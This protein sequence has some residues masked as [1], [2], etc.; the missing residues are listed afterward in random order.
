MLSLPAIQG[1]FPV[2]VT[3]FVTPVRP[4]RPV[5]SAKLKNHLK[6]RPGQPDYAFLLEEV[7]YTAY[8][9]ADVGKLQ[10]KG[11]PWFLRPLRHS[12]NGLAS[13]L[14]VSSW[15]LT[16]IAYCYGA[17]LKI[18]AYANAPLLNPNTVQEFKDKQWP[19]VIFSHGLGGGRTVYSQFCSELAASGKVVIALEHRDGTSPVCMPRGWNED[20]SK[21][22]PRILYY[23]RPTDIELDEGDEAHK[24]PMLLR[25]QQL[26]F[27]KHEVYTAYSTFSRFVRNDSTLELETI[28]GTA[29]PRESWMPAGT[30]LKVKCDDEVTVAGHSFGGCTILSVLS[31]GPLE[32]SPPIPIGHTV[33]LDPWLEPL[34][35]PG[36]VPFSEASS[37][38]LA[39]AEGLVANSIDRATPSS[40]GTKVE[41]SQMKLLVINSEQFTVWKDHY[42]RLKEMLVHWEPQG[43]R[44]LTIVGSRHHAFSDFVLL[45]VIGQKYG[46]F[47]MDRISRLSLAFLDDNL[48]GSLKSLPV[49]D[50]QEEIVGTKKDGKPKRQLIGKVGDIIVE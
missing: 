6:T 39:T 27:R 18:P 50:R 20:G 35:T 22:E 28:D 32:G 7:A 16:P 3:T 1:R 31:S 12:L 38:E 41:E 43:G 4:A 24:N 15:L 49:I 13:F 17:L 48:E 23:L 21:T 47:I 30:T 33:I 34:P 26:S 37:S 9:P 45:P 2:G 10:T 40:Q 11:V 46:R 29:Y 36:P 42:A 25:A 44:L 5:G 8:Y 14:G 19:L